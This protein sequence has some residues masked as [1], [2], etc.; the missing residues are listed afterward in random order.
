[1]GTE[2]PASVE[3]ELYTTSLRPGLLEAWALA[4]K[5]PDTPVINWLRT[6][7]PAGVRHHPE[8]VGIFPVVNEERWRDPEELETP[9]DTFRNY[10]SVEL[11]A[12]AWPEI[13]KFVEKGFIK[14]F[15]TEAACRQFLHGA[16][17]VLSKLGLIIRVRVDSTKKR[18]I[19]D[20]KRS[21]ITAGSIRSERVILP[22]LTDLVDDLLTLM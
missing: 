10:D 21:G 15:D 4:G 5:D 14:T 7:A 19:L 9:A 20:C 16:H 6:G 18:I 2:D 22:M 3:N 8:Q 13:L 1:M 11:D 17:P 12:S